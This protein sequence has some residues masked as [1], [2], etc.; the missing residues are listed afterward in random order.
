MARTREDTG[1]ATRGNR[2]FARRPSAS[3]LAPNI[4]FVVRAEKSVTPSMKKISAPRVF[5]GVIGLITLG[6]LAGCFETKQEFTLNPDGSGKVVHESRFQTMDLSGNKQGSEKQMKAAVGELIGKAR[7]VDAWRDVS[8]ELLDDGRIAFKGT[9]YFRNLSALDIPNQ[10]MLE[11]DWAT[12]DDHTGTLTLRAKDKSAGEKP[13]APSEENI[14]A[15]EAAQKLR[16]SRAQ[17][18]QM[19]PMMAMIMG[20]MKHEVVFHLPGR[21]GKSSAFRKESAGALSLAF[22]GNKMIEA[23]EKLINDDAWMARNAG[24]MNPDSAPPMDEQMSLLLFGDK[25]P[26]QATVTR[27]GEPVFDYEAEVAAAREDFAALQQQLGTGPVAVAAPA[28]SGELKSLTV[29]GVRLARVVD[30]SLE[31]RPFGTNPGFTLS[32]LAELPGSVLSMTDECTLD[33]AI[34]DDGASLLPESEWDRRISFPNLAPDKSRVLFEAQMGLPGPGV[35]G[36]KEVSGRL[37]YRVASGTKEIDLG[38]AQLAAGTAG[39]ELGA[40]LESLGAESGN[41]GPQRVELKLDLKPDDLKALYL[42]VGRTKTE[43]N[44]NGY[45]GYN[46]SYTYTYESESGFPANGRLVA[47]VYAEMQVFNAPFKVENITLL[48]EPMD[49]R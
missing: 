27:L 47:E 35:K 48:G 40:H 19:K 32:L 41:E 37:Q 24:V 2:N 34:A 42:V 7:G 31:N 3:L 49:A 5:A 15:E 30:D 33:T 9:A 11:F 8:Y 23:M 4:A 6:L 26:V 14:S 12:G 28:Q 39:T 29:V 22:D 45:S 13:A 17:Y 20:A 21:P 1:P 25:G 10:T 38:F 16:Q 46:D 18:Q 44:R 36:L 43:L